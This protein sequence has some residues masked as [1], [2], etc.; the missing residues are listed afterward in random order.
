MPPDMRAKSCIIVTSHLWI[1][2]AMDS[3]VTIIAWGI[4]MVKLQVTC[5]RY[6]TYKQHETNAHIRGPPP[7]TTTRCSCS[8]VKV[9][10]Y[11]IKLK[12]VLQVT[13]TLHA[14][15]T[16]PVHLVAVKVN[17]V[18]EKY[19]PDDVQNVRSWMKVGS[20][21]KVFKTRPLLGFLCGYT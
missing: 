17:F 3:D 10:N 12:S 5:D 7:P 11:G 8:Q 9:K 2:L 4:S 6:S 18:P 20:V 13:D 16:P 21:E 1:S 15:N 19:F 14:L